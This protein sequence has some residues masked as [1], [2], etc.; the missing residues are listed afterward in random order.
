[1]RRQWR[2]RDKSGVLEYAC[3]FRHVM[4]LRIAFEQ[5]LFIVDSNPFWNKENFLSFRFVGPLAYVHRD[6]CLHKVAS[7]CSWYPLRRVARYRGVGAGGG[8]GVF[9]LENSSVIFR[10]H[11]RWIVGPHRETEHLRLYFEGRQKYW[12]HEIL[13]PI[14]YRSAV[15]LPLSENCIEKWYPW[16]VRTNK[17]K[18]QCLVFNGN[19]CVGGNKS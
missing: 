1:M 8:V 10:H 6:C 12:P 7:L 11:F 13:N 2:H 4:W 15:C 9:F 16:V 18:T 5:V 17:L 14:Y 3:L 19:N